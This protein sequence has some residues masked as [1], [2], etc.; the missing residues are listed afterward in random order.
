MELLAVLFLQ[1]IDQ[2][3]DKKSYFSKKK[4]LK[5]SVF[6]EVFTQRKFHPLFKFLHFTDNKHYEETTYS[7]R[8]L[9]K[10]KLIL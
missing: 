7:S 10:L 3:S 9:Y 2:K 5:M 1:R 4:T 8:R 6:S